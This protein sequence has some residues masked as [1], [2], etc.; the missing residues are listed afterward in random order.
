MTP[1]V[2]VAMWPAVVGVHLLPA[3]GS[4]IAAVEIDQTG[5]TRI[6][7]PVINHA[8]LLPLIIL[9]QGGMGCALLIAKMGQP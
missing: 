7:A 3:N 6:G 5:S 2:L 1:A 8:F 9:T 4:Q